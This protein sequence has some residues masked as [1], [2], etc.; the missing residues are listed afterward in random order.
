M[1][2]QTTTSME[3]E[4]EDDVV[5]PTPKLRHLASV[6]GKFQ[7]APSS[8]QQCQPSDVQQELDQEASAVAVA[9]SANEILPRQRLEHGLWPNWLMNVQGQPRRIFSTV[10]ALRCEIGILRKR[11]ADSN[12]AA[13]A[14]SE[15]R[16]HA[17]EEGAAAL[18][19]AEAAQKL[20]CVKCERHL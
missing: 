1:S 11:L 17:V 20:N 4:S 16:L 15:F 6:A 12:S 5:A 19:D 9:Q 8:I 14:A 13:L 18:A 10:E 7:Q 3:I 2:V